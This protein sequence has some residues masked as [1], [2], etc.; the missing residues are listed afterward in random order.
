MHNTICLHA[1]SE[2]EKIL[3][4]NECSYNSA[5]YNEAIVSISESIL[6]SLRHIC[7]H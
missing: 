5:L 7:I 6:H 1:L 2:S 4:K 3:I